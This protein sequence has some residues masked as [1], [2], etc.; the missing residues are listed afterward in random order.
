MFPGGKI[1]GE[2]IIFSW[3]AIAFALTFGLILGFRNYMRGP[4]C[5]SKELAK[6]KRVVITGA[7]GGVGLETAKE[8]AGRGAKVILACR[9]EKKGKLAVDEVKEAAKVNHVE[10]MKLDLASLQSVR[11]FV[12]EFTSKYDSLDILINNAGVMYHPEVRTNEGNETHFCINYLGHYLLTRLLMGCLKAVQSARII[13]I[14]CPAYQLAEPDFTDVNWQNKE[15]KPAEAFALSKL[16]VILFT[17][18]LARELEGTNVTANVVHPG[19][20]YTGIYKN[21]P[22]MK[23]KIIAVSFKP[24]LWF[25]MKGARDGAQTVVH[26]AIA[27]EEQGVSGKYYADLCIKEP[28]K[29][30]NDEEA[31]KVL[32]NLSAKMT[33]VPADL[34]S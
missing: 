18:Q 9:D 14:C 13:N 27:K 10:Y 1:P 4:Q 34:S 8:L 6:G 3:Q 17:K 20:C 12:K 30:A 28:D 32:W 33:G 2:D 24:L 29:K 11:D 23:S 7:N 15:H 21:M 26:C 25:L 16:A 22:F 19:V 5:M 31:A